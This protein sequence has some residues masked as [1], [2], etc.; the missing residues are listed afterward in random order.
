MLVRSVSREGQSKVIFMLAVCR[1]KVNHFKG[2]G[3]HA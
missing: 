3:G 1:V 2:V